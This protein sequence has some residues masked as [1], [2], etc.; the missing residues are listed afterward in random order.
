LEG[1]RGPCAM[2]RLRAR[3]V[4]AYA[5]HLLTASGVLLALA[6][7]IEVASAAPDPRRVLLVLAAAIV[8]DAIDGPLARAAH[9]ERHAPAIAGRTIDDI[10]DYLCYAFLPL[11]LVLRMGWAAGP[12]W[13]VLGAIGFALI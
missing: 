13:L 4:A 10:V 2:N 8:I 11:L 7:A 5:V 1:D 3:R 9:V 12:E 6:A